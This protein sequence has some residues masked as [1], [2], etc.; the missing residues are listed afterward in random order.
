MNSTNLYS[1]S[2]RRKTDDENDYN[3][4][5]T[6]TAQNIDRNPSHKTSMSV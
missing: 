5:Y 1:Q 4:K 6:Y 3:K 2:F